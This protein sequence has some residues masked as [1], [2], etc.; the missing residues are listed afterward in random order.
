MPVKING[1][2]QTGQIIDLELRVI[3]LEM[4]VNHLSENKKFVLDNLLKFRKE[5]VRI[6]QEKYPQLNIKDNQG[7]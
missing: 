2:D 3:V 5:G 7:K 4:C 6:L 1:I